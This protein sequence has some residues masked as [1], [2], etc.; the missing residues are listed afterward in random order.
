MSSVFRKGNEF[1]TCAF[2]VQQ[3]TERR[4]DESKIQETGASPDKNKLL[5]I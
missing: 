2:L 1:C 5:G 3:Q 4:N